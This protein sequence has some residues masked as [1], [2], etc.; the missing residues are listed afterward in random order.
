VFQVTDLGTEAPTHYV[1]QAQL[2]HA[3]GLKMNMT[4]RWNG[5]PSIPAHGNVL[6][7]ICSERGSLAIGQSRRGN[8][9]G[10]K[11]TPRQAVA[12]S[13]PGWDY[14]M[15]DRLIA[16]LD[17]CS[18]AIVEKDAGHKEASLVPEDSEAKASPRFERAH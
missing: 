15:A 5:P 13:Y 16:W 14:A 7:P 12:R 10:R 11:L 3:K 18:Y 1:G 6:E 4:V 9:M 2:V 8:S 17:D